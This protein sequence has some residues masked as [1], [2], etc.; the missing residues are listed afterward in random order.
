MSDQGYISAGEQKLHYYKYGK[1]EAV[2]M[3]FHGYGDT[4]KI[5]SLLEPIIGKAYTILAFSLPH[6]AHTEW[7]KETP[8]TKKQLRVLIK[9]TLK[10]FNVSSVSLIGYSMGGRVCLTA[11]ESVPKYIQQVVLLASDGLVFNSFYHFVTQNIFGKRIFRSFLRDPKPYEPII[12]FARRSNIVNQSKYK[13]ATKYLDSE[14]ERKFLLQVWPAMRLL[15]PDHNILNKN[16]REHNI[17]VDVFMGKYDRVIPL[18]HAYKL[19]KKIPSINIHVLEKGHRI[20][21]N[22]TAPKIASVLL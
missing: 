12:S 22:T 4:A 20:L 10:E 16:V 6:H 2:L 5:F 15:I 19:H 18:S 9:N 7:P 3:A 13:F 8:F 17:P 14:E 21:D 1:G 11:L